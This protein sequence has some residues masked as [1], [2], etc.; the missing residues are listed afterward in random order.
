MEHAT[1]YAKQHRH[2]LHSL[3]SDV[4]CWARFTMPSK[5][6]ASNKG[7]G[8]GTQDWAQVVKLLSVLPFALAGSC[9]LQKRKVNENE[10][11]MDNFFTT[12]E[13]KDILTG[14]TYVCLSPGSR[15]QT[16]NQKQAWVWRS[17]VFCECVAVIAYGLVS[18]MDCNWQDTDRQPHEWWCK[19]KVLV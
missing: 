7:R 2:S 9:S 11:R 6:A 18:C 10:L 4:T 1:F 16:D 19:R 17:L 12:C 8:V 3:N 5:G 14:M 13:L 15:D